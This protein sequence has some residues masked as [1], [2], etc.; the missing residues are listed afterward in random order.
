M[1]AS[2]GRSVRSVRHTAPTLDPARNPAFDANK[3]AGERLDLLA[4]LNFYVPKGL[5][6]G[7]RFSLEGGVPVYQNILGP[8]L[9]TDWLITVGC[10][11]TF[12]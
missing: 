10:S 11:Y 1:R 5:L 3:Q 12:H 4:G 2:S 8:N 6:K 7:A 9:A